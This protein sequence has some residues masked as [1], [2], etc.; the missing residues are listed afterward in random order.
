MK[1]SSEELDFRCFE[2]RTIP[3]SAKNDGD[4]EVGRKEKMRKKREMCGKMK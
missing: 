3:K 4:G 1:K 2:L